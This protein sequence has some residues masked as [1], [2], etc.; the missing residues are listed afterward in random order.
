MVFTDFLPQ[1][2]QGR[3]S[4]VPIKASSSP[5]QYDVVPNKNI[6]AMSGRRRGIRFTVC[7][8]EGVQLDAPC[9]QQRPS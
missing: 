3:P 7:P 8:E 4:A 9:A 5:F 1:F 2:Y 6:Q